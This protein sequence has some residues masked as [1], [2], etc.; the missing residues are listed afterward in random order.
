[1]IVSVPV[2]GSFVV[3]LTRA[4]ESSPLVSVPVKGSFVV[5][6]ELKELRPISEFPSP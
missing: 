6:D 5:N 1:M 4:R 3:N 2:K